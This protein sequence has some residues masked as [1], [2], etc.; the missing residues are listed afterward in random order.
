MSIIDYIKGLF[1]GKP[2]EDANQSAN[3]V[4]DE[5]AN[6]DCA[7]DNTPSLENV[8]RFVIQKGICKGA[9]IQR[10]FQIGYKLSG[11]LILQLQQKGILD[12]SYNVLVD[13]NISDHELTQLL[14]KETIKKQIH[15]MLYQP[16][17]LR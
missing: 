8:A 12:S 4:E 13:A 3:V 17:D 16:P 14:N 2:K 10:Y 7:V 6:S 15:I 1:G 11:S 5:S 9:D